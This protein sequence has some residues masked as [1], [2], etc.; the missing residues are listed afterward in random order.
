MRAPGLS[1]PAVPKTV[2][3]ALAAGMALALA[4][5]VSA[6]PPAVTLLFCIH[7]ATEIALGVAMGIGCAAIYDGAYAA[8]RCID[9]YL[10]VRTAMPMANIVTGAEFGRL[11]SNAFLAV[12]FLRGGIEYMVL[13]FAQGVR[14]LPPGIWPRAADFTAYACTLI[15]VL[16]QSAVLIAGPVAAAAL[17]AQ[18]GLALIGRIVPKFSTFALSF[19]LAYGIAIGVTA[20]VLPIFLPLAVHPLYA[21]PFRPGP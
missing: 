16:T 9:D 4:P 13:I 14:Q 17:C 12:L 5:L 15:A 6:G 8:G 19:P 18:T 21:Q 10:G 7:L 20:A 3:A 2:R 11:W 1:H